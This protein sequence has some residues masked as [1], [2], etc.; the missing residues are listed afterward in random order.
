MR[1]SLQEEKIFKNELAIFHRHRELLSQESSSGQM[2]T[3]WE[4]LTVEYKKLLE[5]TRFLTWVSGRL[6]KKL[7]R[8]NHNLQERN[9]QLEK[10]VDDLITAKAGKRAYAIIY[11][12]AIA[13]FVLEEFF[14]EPLINVFGNGVGY[15]IMIK[16][17]I[18]LLLK[19][20]EGVIEERIRKK[21][22]VAAAKSIVNSK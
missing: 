3:S 22:K 9:T 5:Q 8:A 4:N 6:E 21:P 7:Q 12:I 11:F 16:L 15:S 14:I 2:K 17:G 19:V 18:V 20:S 1:K 13:L 10:T